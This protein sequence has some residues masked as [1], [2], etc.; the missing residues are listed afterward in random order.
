ME[1]RSALRREK[2]LELP[3]AAPATEVQFEAPRLSAVIYARRGAVVRKVAWW[4]GVMFLVAVS[5]PA[6]HGMATTPGPMTERLEAGIRAIINVVPGAQAA[7]QADGAEPD[8]ESLLWGQRSDGRGVEDA[9]GDDSQGDQQGGDQ[10]PT[11]P[12]AEDAQGEGG[13]HDTAEGGEAAEPPSGEQADG[14]ADGQGGD[15]SEAPVGDTAASSDGDGLQQGGSS[16]ATGTPIPPPS[17]PAD[18][19]DDAQDDAPQGAATQGPDDISDASDRAVTLR[20]VT[21]G[22][23]LAAWGAGA[24]PGPAEDPMPPAAAASTGTT[25]G[26]AIPPP[27]PAPEPAPAPEVLDGEKR[28]APTV[29]RGVDRPQEPIIEEDSTL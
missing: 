3:G 11:E 19:P 29:L 17:M 22:D 25:A 8:S 5:V 24:G 26:L 6:A 7:A 18:D 21:A 1:G 13:H 12:S 14:P 4:I 9:Q 27:P 16:V 28:I 15:Q 23:A 10:G 20:A 2:S